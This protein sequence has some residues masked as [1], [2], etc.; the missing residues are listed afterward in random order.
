M[1]DLRIIFIVDPDPE[2]ESVLAPALAR[3]GYV[4]QVFGSARTALDCLRAASCDLLVLDLWLPDTFG[5]CLLSIVR[6]LYPRLPS[7]V[8]TG[9]PSVEH[10]LRALQLGACGYLEKPIDPQRV[11]LCIE[12]VLK[13]Q[14]RPGLP[15]RRARPRRARTEI[16]F[17]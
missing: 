17:E 14:P 8:V 10:T 7:L 6:R 12:Q 2:A 13:A 15:R 1:T 11:V 16:D 5:L 4:V 9:E 3:A